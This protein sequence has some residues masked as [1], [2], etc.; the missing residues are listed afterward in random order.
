MISILNAI[1]LFII[2]NELVIILALAR[3]SYVLYKH[4][5][6]FVNNTKAIIELSNIIK[7]N[8]GWT[9][10]KD[11]ARVVSIAKDLSNIIIK[12]DINDKEKK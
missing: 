7:R 3:R 1:L 5:M 12:D 11:L 2:F 10:N 4:N 6:T 8:T 9:K